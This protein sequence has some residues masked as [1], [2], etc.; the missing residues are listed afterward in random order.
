MN[1]ARM[2]GSNGLG[3]VTRLQLNISDYAF[4]KAHS[5]EWVRTDDGTS[6]GT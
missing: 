1:N 6:L 5:D 4:M 3:F 2:L